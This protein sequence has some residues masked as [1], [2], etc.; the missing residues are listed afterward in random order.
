MR[1]HITH[2]LATAAIAVILTGCVTT[3]PPAATSALPERYNLPATPRQQTPTPEGAIFN[4]SSN[5]G[6]YTD[7]RARA[8]GDII[9]VKIVETSNGSKKASTKTGRN[10]GIDSAVVI[11]LAV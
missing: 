7:S 10:L 6:L 5:Q 3:Q 4:A 8:V 1:K 11:A 9:L 2:T